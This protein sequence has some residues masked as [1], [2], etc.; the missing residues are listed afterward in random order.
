MEEKS[1]KD[2]GQ[3]R[4]EYTLE[5]LEEGKLPEDPMELLDKWMEEAGRSAHPDPTAMTLTTVNEKGFLSSRIVLLKQVKEGR[6]IFFSNYHS[7]KAREMENSSQ[8]AGHFYWPELERQIKIGGTVER[9]GEE[10]SDLYFQSRPRESQ[11]AAWASPQSEEIPNREYLEEEYQKYL[12]KFQ[13]TEQIPRPAYWGGFAISPRQIE[14]W[15]GG[16]HRLHD[17]I[18]Y[19]LEEGQWRWL[20]LAP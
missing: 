2:L 16:R 14:F 3:V 19:R 18:E 11:I 8:L 6:L 9:L 1:H 10:E 17:R 12:S 4:R 20:R 13:E 7:R 15:Q 5:R